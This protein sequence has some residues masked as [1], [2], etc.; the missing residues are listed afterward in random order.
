MA[1]YMSAASSARWRWFG[2]A[3]VVGLALAAVVAVI[4]KRW[5]LARIVDGAARRGV[6]LAGCELDLGIRSWSLRGC[7]FSLL[8]G[9]LERLP[10]SSAG[11]KGKI[12]QIELLL[13]GLRP[14]K[15]IVRE[16]RVELSGRP[17]WRD[18]AGR[19]PSSELPSAVEVERGTVIFRFVE[20]TEPDLTLSGVRYATDTGELGA[21]LTGHALG[22]RG[23]LLVRDEKLVVSLGAPE[24][25]PA[26]FELQTLPAEQR[27]ELRLSLQRLP[28]GSLESPKLPLTPALREIELEGW[29]VARIPFGLQSERPG[30]ELRLTLHGLQFPV[31]RELEGLIHDS[32]PV[33]SAR[34]AATHSFDRVDIEPVSFLTGQ[35]SMRGAGTLKRDVASSD[36]AFEGRLSGPL[37]CRAVAQA[38]VSAHMGS[39]LGKLAGRA[40]KQTL[41]GDLRVFAALS[42]HLE[43][44]P[45]ARVV[46]SVGVGCGLSP[47]PLDVE[48]AGALLQGLPDLAEQLPSVEGLRWP[49]WREREPVTKPV[50]RRR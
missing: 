36:L 24:H 6:A 13:S 7:E 27:L 14:V 10:L 21:S 3:L 44:L 11:A 4:G 9:A 20:N 31:P 18:L 37:S 38:A 47:L 19:Q 48:G 35:L 39:T 1:R 8:P 46:T 29:V 41:S 22:L 12:A 5:A 33:V 25:P 15:L 50:P 28:L 17:R 26:R 42:G 32:P 23:E 40:A 45:R 34:F 49:T 43:Q 16:P 30:G 2:G